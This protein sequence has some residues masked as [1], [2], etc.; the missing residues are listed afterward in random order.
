MTAARR[1]PAR[2]TDRDDYQDV[3]RP[4]AAMAKDFAAGRLTGTWPNQGRYPRS[5]TVVITRADG[6]IIGA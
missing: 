6:G 3:P 5:A 1:P 4:V 2:S